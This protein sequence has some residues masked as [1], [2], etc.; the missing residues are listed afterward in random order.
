MFNRSAWS[1]ALLKRQRLPS[2][3]PALCSRK[4]VL[5]LMVSSLTE[6]RLVQVRTITFPGTPTATLIAAGSKSLSQKPNSGEPQLEPARGAP[7]PRPSIES[8]TRAEVLPVFFPDD[9]DSGRIAP[10]SG[11]AASDPDPDLGSYQHSSLVH[12][13]CC[14]HHC[15]CRGFRAGGRPASGA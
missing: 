4:R 6:C 1:S 9:A 13:A 8:K 11:C 5:P 12:Y 3:G 7:R 14:R 10:K 15:G 2:R